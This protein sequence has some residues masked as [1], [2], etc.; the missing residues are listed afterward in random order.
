MLDL[1]CASL[2]GETLEDR[3]IM[4][5]SYVAAMEPQDVGIQESFRSIRG[6]LKH[7]ELL[8]VSVSFPTVPAA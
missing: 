2:E 7:L 3:H 5:W 8:T 6:I 1:V 4:R